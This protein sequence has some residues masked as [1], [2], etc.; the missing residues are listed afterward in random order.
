MRKKYDIIQ[1]VKLIISQIRH[2]NVNNNNILSSF[3]HIFLN[4]EIKKAS[5]SDFFY[6]LR[7]KRLLYEMWLLVYL[8]LKLFLFLISDQGSE[9]QAQAWVCRR[10][11][12]VSEYY[13]NWLSLQTARN[14]PVGQ[15]PRTQAHV[16]TGLTLRSIQERQGRLRWETDVTLLAASKIHM[17]I[18]KGHLRNLTSVSSAYWL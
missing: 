9:S 16:L 12:G 2:L 11:C 17:C 6:I 1:N 4:R 18:M 10:R 8:G 5:S 15:D 3:V 13:N 7:F 14:C